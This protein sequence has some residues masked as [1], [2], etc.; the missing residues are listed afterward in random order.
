VTA[1]RNRNLLKEIDCI[2]E[3]VVVNDS[4]MVAM[5]ASMASLAFRFLKKKPDLYFDLEV[6][7]WLSTFIAA[8]SFSRRTFG[9]YRES[10][11]IRKP[12]YSGFC[13]FGKDTVTDSYEALAKLA[14]VSTIQQPL[15]SFPAVQPAKRK[16]YFL[17]NPNAS[18]L[19]L[20]RRW[21][22]EKFA[23]LITSL[24]EIYPE[25]DVVV[26]G[27]ASEKNLVDSVSAEAAVSFPGRV[28]NLCGRLSEKEFIGIVAGCKMM[29]TNDSGP[30][31]LAMALQRPMVA[32]FGPGDP[33]QYAF[34]DNARVLYKKISCSPCV[35]LHPQSPCNG[36][37]QC[38]KLISTS[39]VLETCRSLLSPVPGG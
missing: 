12:V 1:A 20:E 13:L 29:L 39:E 19:R 31:H 15:Y 16:N 36:D 6:Y 18:D 10:S 21:P 26:T 32:L 8:V 27:S 34:P 5:S 30:M 2:D 28:H 35:H 24:L 3:I 22:A 7:S 38:M 17:V 11:A 9:L 23:R 37:N 4:G 14:G 33:A 25:Y